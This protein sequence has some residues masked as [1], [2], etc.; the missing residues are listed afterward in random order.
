MIDYPGSC[1]L[2]ATD[3]P[4]EIIKNSLNLTKEYRWES[5][6]WAILQT[7]DN[8]NQENEELLREILYFSGEYGLNENSEFPHSKSPEAMARFLAAQAFCKWYNLDLNEMN[9]IVNIKPIC[10]QLVDAKLRGEVNVDDTFVTS[11]SATHKILN[12]IRVIV[13]K[14]EDYTAI[15]KSANLA[16]QG[17]TQEEAID[18]LKDIIVNRFDFVTKNRSWL[19]SNLLNLLH[20]LEHYV[21]R[22]DGF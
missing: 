10:P 12:N 4:S 19:C 6:L 13:T 3:T 21:G 5:L 8:R 18:N 11:L 17:S 1:P 20:I 9:E 15:F 22:E 14:G 16:A 7:M 2:D